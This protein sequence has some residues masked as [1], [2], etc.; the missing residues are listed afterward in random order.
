M[1]EKGGM[2][3][4]WFC[5]GHYFTKK[6]LQNF[7]LFFHRQDCVENEITLKIMDEFTH[8]IEDSTMTQKTP[9]PKRHNLSLMQQETKI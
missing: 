5:V 7:I 2:G 9:I 1:W 8:K 6:M 3:D 4:G